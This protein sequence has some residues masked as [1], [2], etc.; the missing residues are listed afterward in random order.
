MANVDAALGF[1]PVR[2]EYGGVPKLEAFQVTAAVEIF[3]GSPVCIA[4]TG[5]RHL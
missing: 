5:G 2:N 1:R 4:G 3:E